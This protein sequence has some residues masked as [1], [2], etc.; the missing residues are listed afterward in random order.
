MAD[1]LLIGLQTTFGVGENQ[2]VVTR[3]L[4]MDIIKLLLYKYVDALIA[5][6]SVI[7]HPVCIPKTICFHTSH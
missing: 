2:E 5:S 7:H 4:E 3:R 1:C 6:G